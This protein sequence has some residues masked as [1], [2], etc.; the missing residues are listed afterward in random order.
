VRFLALAFLFCGTAGAAERGHWLRDH[1]TGEL[2]VGSGGWRS[3]ISSSDHAPG[4]DE[5]AGGA[6]LLLGLEVGSGFAIVGSGRVLAGGDYLEGLA[7]LGL[8]LHVSDRVRIRASPAAGQLSLKADKGVLVG[9]FVAG[10]ID[11]I[12]FGGGRVA[13]T[14]GLR[15]DIDGVLGGGLELPD[16]T[17]SLAIGVGLRY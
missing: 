4:F 17:L 2:F 1:F 14:I 16:S 3:S 7:G 9:G 11:L 5:L 15:L 13:A 12:P 10:S 8:Q 6:E